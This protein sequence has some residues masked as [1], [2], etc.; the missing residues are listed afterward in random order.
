M[1]PSPNPALFSSA[2]VR[3]RIVKILLVVGAVV[4][5]LALLIEAV[6]LS[7]PSLIDDEDFS[8]NPTGAVFVLAAFMLAVAELIIY[9]ATVVVFLM[10]LYRV[11]ANLRAFNPPR[12]LEH[13]PGWAVGSFFIPIANLFLPYRAVREIW[14][15]SEPADELSISEP[16]PPAWFPVWWT[17]WLLSS[18]AGNISMRV[19]FNE[20]VSLKTATMISMVA[21]ALSIIAA[22]FAYVV[23]DLID[24]KQEEASG[25]LSVGRFTGPPPPPVNLS[26]SEVVTSTPAANTSQE[27]FRP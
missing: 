24:Q 6:S 23:V 8:D 3:A 9:V 25:K 4:A 22:V 5:G 15:K 7:S 13:S 17:F 1:N 26:M 21:S 20:N 11:S 10:W 27:I 12:R 18:F 14:Q 19:S 2:Q 16:G